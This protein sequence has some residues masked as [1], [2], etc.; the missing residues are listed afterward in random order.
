M[1][2]TDVV[3]VGLSPVI[4]DVSASAPATAPIAALA[5]DV[6]AHSTSRSLTLSHRVAIICG[7]SVLAYFFVIAKVAANAIHG[8]R[9]AYLVIVPLWAA[10]IAV[11]YRRAAPRGVG[12]NESDWIV[13]TLLAGGG[14]TAIQLISHRLPTLASLWHLDLIGVVVW[15]A[16]CAIIMLGVR[17]VTRMR[18]L[19]LFLLCCATPF[20]YLLGTAGLGGS[21]LA[22]TLV[23]A[24][25]GAV[26][27]FMSGREASLR[28]RAA[29]ALAS[30]ILSTAAAFALAQTNLSISV[31]VAAGL[32]PV[33]ASVALFRWTR[34]DRGPAHGPAGFPNR[35]PVSLIALVLAAAA[36]L[37]LHP[38]EIRQTAFSS[39]TA[40]WT[41]RAGLT[42]AEQFPFITRL[43]GPD[44]T[45]TRYTVANVSG[46]P[47][48]AVDVISATDQA[49]LTD[50]SDVIW[51]STDTPVNYEPAYFG[52]TR[53]PIRT[54][55][56]NA[57][58]AID[59]AS[60]DWY[61]VN[62]SWHTGAR[63][64]LVTVIVNQDWDTSHP[65]P[66]PQPLSLRETLT[67]PTVWLARQQTA[68]IGAVSDRVMQRSAELVRRLMSAAEIPAR[69]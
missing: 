30:M 25:L 45:L 6:D 43:L 55:H 64:Q 68:S 39:A 4:V 61:A 3:H 65:P 21:T 5:I 17:H 58:V 44:A 9:T 34:D 24:A 59:G 50:Y 23:A 2:Q 49:S 37:L 7:L 14:L 53:V 63:Y 19:W 67:G 35:S 11:G 33:L 15:I 1:H 31:M 8:S 48:A 20:P 28:F 47:N 16:S 60:S 12:D 18:D 13:A 41:Q 36:L 22:A 27:V 42:S 51:Y 38:G 56:S 62:W 69:A 54:V 52:N 66:A 40:N 10:M 46:L 26:A 57:D 32:V 29:A